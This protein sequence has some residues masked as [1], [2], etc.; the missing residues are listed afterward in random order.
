[1]QNS[2]DPT[3]ARVLR[4]IKHYRSKIKN[5]PHVKDHIKAHLKKKDQAKYG[6]NPSDA[7]IS[8]GDAYRDFASWQGKPSKTA[9]LP[10]RLGGMLDGNRPPELNTLPDPV[11][12]KQVEWQKGNSKIKAD[13]RADGAI[14][15]KDANGNELDEAHEYMH[16]IF[17]VILYEIRKL[18]DTINSTLEL[19]A[20]QYSETNPA[21]TEA[22]A[23]LSAVT[24]FNEYE[25]SLQPGG[26]SPYSGAFTLVGI[27]PV[28]TNEGFVVSC[29]V[30]LNW[31]NPYHS[32]STIMV[33]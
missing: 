18:L 25:A 9:T 1:M 21:Q 6:N 12:N 29:R 30:K 28:V 16:G 7:L 26:R 20:E 5:D 32:S 24:A 27:Y 33:P 13:V 19:Y 31:K 17:N 14:V 2:I 10:N 11:P 23:Y 22:G 15:H 8:S 3:K 4:D